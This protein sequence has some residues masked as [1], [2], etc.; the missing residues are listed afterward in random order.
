MELIKWAALS[1]VTALT[2]GIAGFGFATR[3][4]VVVWYHLVAIVLSVFLISLS[5]SFL[6]DWLR[7][8]LSIRFFEVVIGLVLVGI[9]IVL[10]LTPPLYPGGKD[11]LLLTLA[12]QL[13][14]GLFSLSYGLSHGRG[15]GMA[16]FISL[17]LLGS[18]LGGMML[19]QRRWS[20]WRLNLALPYLA[21]VAMILIGLIRML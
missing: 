17:L 15:T 3:R 12:V 4:V 14:T 21:S 9:G 18:M 7:D 10:T 20:N 16:V 8:F 5:F 13:D 19:G 1:L 2:A 6:G 11:L